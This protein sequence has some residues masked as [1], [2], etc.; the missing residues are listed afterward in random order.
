MEGVRHTWVEPVAPPPPPPP[1]RDR[2]IGDRPIAGYG[3][4]VAAF[5]FD[6]GLAFAAGV[7]V[8]FLAG[9]AETWATGGGDTA[10]LLVVIG[11]W[12]L[13]TTGATAILGGR[14][15]GKWL[16][17]T[18]VVG[19]GGPAD[20]GTSVL[21]DQLARLL[22]LVPFF[23]LAD[24]IWA[25]ADADRRSLRDKMVGT[26]VVRDRGTMFRAWAVGA[27]AVALLA[28]WVAGTSALDPDV[29]GGYSAS[30]RAEFVDACRDE[31]G[32]RSEC[33]CLFAYL[34]TRVSHD[35]FARIDSDD[36]KDWPPRLRRV[37]LEAGRRCSGGD[38]PAPGTQPA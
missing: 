16:V 35:E 34:A 14:T 1:A 4:R 33:E 12:L 38:E 13:I 7:L 11:A 37:T 22:Y 2:I 24:V 20:F 8:A 5:L 10:F 21:R 23:G 25:A 19:P 31:G 30:E 15:L 6:V 26:Y 27:A 18:R 17:G 32:T 29:G 36:I 9:G 28:V 3:Y